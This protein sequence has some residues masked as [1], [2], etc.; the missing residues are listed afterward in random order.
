VRDT[1]SNEYRLAVMANNF[2]AYSLEP[3][4][5][6]MFQLEWD[7]EEAF[8]SEARVARTGDHLVQL[9]EDLQGQ[10]KNVLNGR[11]VNDD[12]AAQVKKLRAAANKAKETGEE[13]QVACDGN[14]RAPVSESQ[15]CQDGF[16]RL[17]GSY[18]A[19]DRALQ[20]IVR[21]L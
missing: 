7:I 14:A 21:W 10:L 19:L 15:S 6:A 13:V 18:L 11:P 2:S 16:E 4:S 17:L 5:E 1:S 20:P 12:A 3:F 8:A 9:V